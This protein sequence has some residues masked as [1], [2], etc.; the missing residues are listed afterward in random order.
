MLSL[1][2]P[3][4]DMFNASYAAIGER[5]QKTLDGL[6]YRQDVEQYM[7]NNFNTDASVLYNKLKAKYYQRDWFVAVFWFHNEQD[8]SV[9]A[10][11]YFDD[12][13]YWVK[14]YNGKNAVALS[15]PTNINTKRAEFSSSAATGIDNFECDKKYRNAQQ[16]VTQMHDTGCRDCSVGS[17]IEDYKWRCRLGIG[18]VELVCKSKA[19]TYS[20]F[21]TGDL[22]SIKQRGS[23]GKYDCG[24]NFDITCNPNF[25]YKLYNLPPTRRFIVPEFEK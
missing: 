4:L 1:S 5:I 7:R 20:S 17:I 23:C 12:A 18:I 16:P 9:E 14:N 25:P 2:A 8:G 10:T 13:F 21:K 15:F 22:V 3:V 19:K 24:F 11:Q 6:E